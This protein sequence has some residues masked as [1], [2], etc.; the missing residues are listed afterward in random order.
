M[1]LI[2]F[3]KNYLYRDVY[4]IQQFL[5]LLLT[6]KSAVGLGSCLYR[7]ESRL[8]PACDHRP[9]T[10]AVQ[11]NFTPFNKGQYTTTLNLSVSMRYPPTTLKQRYKIYDLKKKIC[12]IF[13]KVCFHSSYHVSCIQIPKSGHT[14]L[15]SVPTQQKDYETEHISWCSTSAAS[16]IHC[17]WHE[18]LR[19]TWQL[20][21][22]LVYTPLVLTL[23]RWALA[24]LKRPL[25]FVN[26]FEL[27]QLCHEPFVW[28]DAKST[29]LNQGEGISEK[30]MF[31]K[32]NYNAIYWCENIRTDWASKICWSV[33]S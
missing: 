23:L 24:V 21:V 5:L 32:R 3:V 29:L 27:L 17:L 30:W 2:L 19:L 31:P 10:H 11:V 9:T 15:V 4:E 12:K 8:S 6:A 20:I 1:T 25:R 16:H 13:I 7:G 33:T 28:I 22:H 18:N 26:W 14:E